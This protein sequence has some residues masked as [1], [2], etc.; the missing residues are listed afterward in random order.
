MAVTKKPARTTRI[1]FLAMSIFSRCVVRIALGC[2]FLLTAGGGDLYLQRFHQ[3]QH[4]A[5]PPPRIS[6]RRLLAQVPATC[7]I[8]VHCECLQKK[9]ANFPSE[10][11]ASHTRKKQC[12]ESI[13]AGKSLSLLNSPVGVWG[14]PQVPYGIVF[15]F[16][17]YIR[18]F[19]F[20]HTKTL[21]EYFDAF[22]NRVGLR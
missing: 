5:I 1:W 9:E 13:P 20:A 21:Y 3:R 15:L 2:R 11:A 7:L 18:I 12:R 10:N 4:L 16:Y 19:I 22:E 17:L 14:T 8:L 6:R